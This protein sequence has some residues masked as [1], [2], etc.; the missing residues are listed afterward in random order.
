M[1][2]MLKK[3]SCIKEMEQIIRSKTEAC[4]TCTWYLNGVC[5][6]SCELAEDNHKICADLYDADYRK[7]EWISV[8][9]RLPEREGKYIA[10][11]TRGTIEI[12]RFYSYYVNDKPQFD[13]WITHWMPLPQPPETKG[14]TE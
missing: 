2:N 5:D 11:T 13:Y 6:D 12:A 4:Q 14:E 9:D 1:E 8:E 7:Q 3:E 10:Y